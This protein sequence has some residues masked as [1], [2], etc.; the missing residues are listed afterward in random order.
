MS[1]DHIAYSDRDPRVRA[2][3][4]LNAS[5]DTACAKAY[6]DESE[7]VRAAAVLNASQDVADSKVYSDRSPLVRLQL[8]NQKL[9]VQRPWR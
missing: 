3:A 8:P 4:M 7:L 6:N 9:V 5:R 1:N 2:A